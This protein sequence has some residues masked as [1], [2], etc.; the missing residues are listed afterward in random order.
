[1]L[2]Q[3]APAASASVGVVGRCCL[4]WAAVPEVGKMDPKF[5]VTPQISGASVI[6]IRSLD[7]LAKEHGT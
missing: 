1:M 2:L 7:S 6:W 3:R 5:A 4:L